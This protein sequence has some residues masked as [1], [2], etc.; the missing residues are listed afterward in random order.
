[1]AI[2]VRRT[3]VMWTG[4]LA[5][6]EGR[7]TDGSS[8]ALDGFPLSLPSRVERADGRTSP[9]ELLAAAHAACFAMALTGTLEQAGLRADEVTVRAVCTLDRIGDQF[10]ITTMALEVAALGVGRDALTAAVATAETGCPI[11]A[12]LRGS[13]DVTVQVGEAPAE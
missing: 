12:A 8:G 7:M 1:M 4:G 11:S 3:T 13:V 2:A 10:R 6:G 9:E 5:G